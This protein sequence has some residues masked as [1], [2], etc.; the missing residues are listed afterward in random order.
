MN[1]GDSVQQVIKVVVVVGMSAKSTRQ[2]S[3][4]AK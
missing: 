1:L 2:R 4:S 3:S